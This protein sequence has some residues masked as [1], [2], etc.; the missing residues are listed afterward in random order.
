M[1]RLSVEVD[2]AEVDTAL[3]ALLRR[4][5]RE[6]KVP[7]FRPGKVPRKVIE[8]RMGGRSALRGEALREALPDFYAK[9]VVD[10]E[11]DP[12]AAPS[13]D[14]TAGEA[15]GD[16]TFDAVVEVRPVVSIA[17]YQ[18]LVVTIPSLEVP[19]ADVAGQLDRLRATAGELVEVARPVQTGDQITID[20][21]G[22]RSGGD[23]ADDDLSTQDF[24]YEVGSAAV[25]PELDEHVVGA[26]VGDV[27]EFESKVPNLEE[28]VAFR[29]DVKEVKELVLPEVTDEWAAEASEFS[30]VDELVADIT[31]RLSGLRLAQARAA[32][33]RNTLDALVELV[34]DDVPEVLVDDE[35]RE[36]I[37]DLTHRFEQQGISVEQFLSATGQSEQEFVDGLRSA[38][39]HAVRA[40][41]AL[42]ALAD[43]EDIEL[44]D[45]DLEA[46]LAAMGERLDIP[47]DQVRSRLDQAGRLPAVRSEQR[48]AKALSWLLDHVELVDD[49]GRAVPREALEA[50]DEEEEGA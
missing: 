28:T 6:V 41:L 18:G 43:A 39:E 17:G 16:V 29:V 33:R 45:E 22:S 21:T 31:T 48:K 9:A 20:V 2:E 34:S 11:V 14:I 32:L 35:L 37:H 10:T 5:S 15:G 24:L 4:L 30:N 36:R 46:E 13:I 42:R 44:A 7:G 1:V 50:D 27:V 40:D 47:A 38:A 3:D 23:G 49:E 19:E 26:K 25:V 12:I 8:A